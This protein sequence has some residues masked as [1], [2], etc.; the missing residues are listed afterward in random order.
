MDKTISLSI[1]PTENFRNSQMAVTDEMNEYNS[2]Y[3]FSQDPFNL[4]YDPRFFFLAEGHREALASIIYGVNERK[5]FILVSGEAGIGKSALIQNLPNGLGPKVRMVLIDQT[6]ITIEQL[7]IE[8]LSKLGLPVRD[9]GKGSLVHQLNNILVQMLAR[10]E[11]LAIVVDKAHKLSQDTMEELRLL[12][13]LETTN[14]KLL[15]VVLVG[16]PEIDAR[17]DSKDLRQLRQRIAVRTGMGRLTEEESGRYIDH[18][19]NNVGSSSSKVFTPGGLSLIYQC[20]KGIPR[21]INIICDN[22]FRTGYGL[23]RAKVNTPIVKKVIKRSPFRKMVPALVCLAIAVFLGREYINIL[24]GTRASK[25]SIPH[26]TFS[27]K[28]ATPESEVKT[29]TQLLSKDVSIPAS[30]GKPPSAKLVKSVLLPSDSRPQ[31]DGKEG[32][33]KIIEVEEGET[34]SSISKKFYNLTNTTLTEKILDFNSEITN[35][36]LILVRQ[37]IKIPEITE[38]SLVI[39]SYPNTYK[40]YMGTFGRAEDAWRYRDEIALKG[41]EIEV[42]PRR[43]S[44]SETW[45]RVVAGKFS[46]KEETLKMISLLKEKGLLPAFALSPKN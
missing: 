33:K 1:N 36:D 11:N 46:T 19:L 31:S 28:V 21:N 6:D 2:Y 5:G 10:D 45:Y 27:G 42:I 18:R 3:G 9:Q 7:L 24:P 26:P 30:E 35:P 22:A 25:P 14:E 13:N 43:I 17:L 39:E 16:Q 34:L 15:Q 38:E 32:F 4:T 12:S 23:S 44:P 41:K 29:Q 8:V 20:S 40:V 37:K